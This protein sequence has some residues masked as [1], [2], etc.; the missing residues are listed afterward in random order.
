MAKLTAE[1][2]ALI[3]AVTPLVATCGGFGFPN[4]TPKGSLRV[5]D[6][7]T[8]VFSELAGGKTYHNL[9]DRPSA[10]VLVL[11]LEKKAGYQIKGSAKIMDQGELFNAAVEQ[12]KARAGRPPQYVV[13]IDVAEVWSVWPGQTDEQISA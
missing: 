8:L 11:D 13:R 9:K 12:S 10:S 3:G 7:E 6:D 5:V 4:V 1:V 2:K